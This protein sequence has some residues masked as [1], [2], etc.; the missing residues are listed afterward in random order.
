MPANYDIKLTKT[1]GS[2]SEVKLTLD[3][4]TQSG[5][6]AVEHISPAPPNQATDAANY[7]QQSPDLGLVLDQDSFH[8]GFGQS[9][10]ERFDDASSANAALSRYA[11]SEGVLGMFKGEMVLG[12][13]EDEVNVLLRNGTLEN[14]GVSEFTGTDVTI[15]VDSD[16][17]RTGDF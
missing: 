10:L 4:T 16:T 7:Q 15:A 9:L 17:V 2:S 6:Y 3:R 14:G 13:K 11:Y 12:Y 1:D 8:R 5:G